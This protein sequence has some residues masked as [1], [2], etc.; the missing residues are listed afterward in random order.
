M[1][2]AIAGR[3]ATNM[4][5]LR[6]ARG[7]TQQRISK[8]ADVPRAT[9]A[10][11]ES[12]ISNPTLNVLIKVAEALGVRLEELIGPP[13]TTAWLYPKGSLPTKSRGKAEIRRL[14]PEALSGLEIERFELPA[15]AHFTG[16]PHTQGTRE[17]LTCE[18]G[19]LDLAVGGECFT[20]KPGDVVVFHGDQPHSY[21][22][23]GRSAAIAYSVVAFAR[24]AT[25]N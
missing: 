20:L 25:P 15:G 3:L 14:L 13:R 12:G 8:L 21:R 16:I 22:N 7:L 9:W 2:E 24:G 23:G 17:Y 11:L 1:D 5:T 18:R 4:R 10:T 6:E 19:S